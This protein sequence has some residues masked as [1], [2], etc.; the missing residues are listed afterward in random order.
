VRLLVR[1]LVV[2]YLSLFG[3]PSP[4]LALEGGVCPAV[5]AARFV[6]LV[7]RATASSDYSSSVPVLREPCGCPA[8]P[9][10]VPLPAQVNSTIGN[11]SAFNDHSSALKDGSSVSHDRENG[12]LSSALSL[13]YDAPRLLRVSHSGM[14]TKPGTLLRGDG[15]AAA[16]IF[17]DG[18]TARNPAM[19]IEEHLAGGERFDRDFEEQVCRHR[20]CSKNKGLIYVIDDVGSNAVKYRRAS[21][22]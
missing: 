21:T 11:L 16:E 10:L 7:G 20:V 14:A 12:L 5:P 13:G 2:L 3:G 19:S 4:A 6:G 9:A 17:G 22:L 1:I 15:R 8:V 18:M